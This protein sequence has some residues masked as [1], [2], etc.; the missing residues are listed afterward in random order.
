MSVIIGVDPHKAT[1]QAVAVDDR[2]NE[3]D[4]I[5]VRATSTQTQRLLAWAAP[6]GSRAWAIEGAEGLGYLL[7][8]QLVANGERVVNV[9][10]TLAAL[11]TGPVGSGLNRVDNWNRVSSGLA[12]STSPMSSVV[13]APEN[14]GPEQD[15]APPA[16]PSWSCIYFLLQ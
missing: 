1:H 6:F 12:P 11:P 10:A 8:Q 3:I 13:T 15:A 2:E 7:S 16:R 9:P 14:F 4:R 5:S